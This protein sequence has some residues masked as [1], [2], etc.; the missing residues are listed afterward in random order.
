MAIINYVYKYPNKS[1]LYTLSIT[2]ILEVCFIHRINYI[3]KKVGK[4][5]G[6][7]YRDVKKIIHKFLIGYSKHI[8]R[9]LNQFY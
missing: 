7:I 6:I 5:K 8:I 1:L 9:S 2:V 4:P 3:N